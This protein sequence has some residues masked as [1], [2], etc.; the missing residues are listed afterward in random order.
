M[1]DEALFLGGDAPRVTTA[2][3]AHLSASQQFGAGLILAAMAIVLLVILAGCLD[4]N[5]GPRR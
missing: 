2:L 1:P 3:A 5:Q 4:A